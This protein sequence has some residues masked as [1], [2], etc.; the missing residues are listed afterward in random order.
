MNFANVLVYVALVGY[1]LFRKVQGQPVGTP[2]R[3]FALPII[4]I[5]LGYGDLAYGG[6]SHPIDIALT[7]IGA[8]VSLALG[9][10]R[11]RT[12]RL[13]VRDGSPYVKWGRASV[14]LFITNIAAKLVLDLIGVA[15]GA[16]SSAVEKSLLL[17]FGLTL[18]GE[19]AVVWMRTGGAAG[20][21]ALRQT[22]RTRF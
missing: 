12:D 17:S 13:S 2:K 18:L 21:L 7:V 6:T 22:I 19:A 3:L 15:C 20:L 8:T 10:L 4:L 5:V 9:L 16:T 11:G 14:I 1:V